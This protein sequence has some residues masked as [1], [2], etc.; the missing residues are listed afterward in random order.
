MKRR[1]DVCLALVFYAGIVLT[2]GGALLY[3][4]LV[5]RTERPWTN[6]VAIV[7]I[8]AFQC[9]AAITFLIARESPPGRRKSTGY[10]IA[11][12]SFAAIFRVPYVLFQSRV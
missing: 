2:F 5:S 11:F 8:F 9:Q 3:S 1:D 10:L 7:S 6:D 4:R 12:G